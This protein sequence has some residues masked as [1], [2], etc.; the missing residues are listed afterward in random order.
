MIEWFE[1]V[2]LW[3]FLLEGTTDFN[4]ITIIRMIDNDECDC[5]GDL[6]ISLNTHLKYYQFLNIQI[7]LINDI[8]LIYSI[9][10]SKLSF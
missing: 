3:S 8:I 9:D 1:Q 10:Q 5:D 4:Y 6:L 2:K 7:L